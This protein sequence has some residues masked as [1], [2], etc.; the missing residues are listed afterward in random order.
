[1][2]LFRLRSRSLIT[3]LLALVVLPILILLIIVSYQGVSLHEH[4]MRALVGERDERAVRA[5]AQVLS[6]RFVQRRLTLKVIADRLADGV[7]LAQ[8][9]DGEPA[10]R[11]AFDM[12]L[13]VLNQ[14]GGEL[15]RWLPA[16]VWSPDLHNQSSPWI[17]D[18][19]VPQPLV[20]TKVQSTN[21]T[22]TLFGGLSLSS[23]NVSGAL[24]IIRNN[25]QVRV[26]LVADDGHV[27]EDTAGA[28]IGTN[29]SDW[30]GVKLDTVQHSSIEHDKDD[31]ITVSSRI[32]Q[33]DWTLVAQ[34]PWHT[35]VSPT[36]QLSL[37]APLAMIPAVILAVFVLMFG[38]TRIVLPLQRLGRAAS[39]LAWGDY[40]SIRQPVG[41]VQEVHDLQTT[42]S[43]MAQRLQQ[44][45][46]GMHSYIAAM[47]Q[48]Q[49][50]ERK[51][52][53]RELH[54]DTLQ[55][56]IALD[57]QRQMAL[58]AVPTDPAKASRHLEQLHA[59]LDETVNSLR[60]LI[61]DM[62]PSYI[63]DLG[64]TP[65]LEA[66]ATQQSTAGQITINFTVHGAPTRLPIN[67]ELGLYRIAQE[68]ITNAVRHGHAT[69]IDIA[70][71]F[72]EAVILT[73]QDN[74]RGF[75]VPDRPGVLAQSG[76][77]GL[78]GMVERAEQM[79]GQFRIHATLGKGTL[80][81]VRLP[82]G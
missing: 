77:Y 68:A 64:L 80:I 12:G 1:M 69:Q 28:A 52:L 82:N 2:S 67:H 58:R 42:L 72:V 31:L 21:G 76:H 61:R 70:L 73:I 14:N 79:Q 23:L 43:H 51:R 40:E 63:E 20:I 26:Y 39:Q 35:V 30:P 49:E 9:L 50:D 18:H 37:V 11:E 16:F 47:L 3:Q 27:L 36:L 10:L 22:L 71:H 29:A 59:M 13:I 17:V 56:L 5:A 15:D 44:A 25:P 4:A 53:S 34:E 55:S 38:M 6:D 57:Q 78:M 45:Q 74:G 19:D 24:G 60:R 41:G 46:T 7:R 66:L 62:R 33:L 54:D 81:E 48:G 8:I 65:A 75:A 32:G